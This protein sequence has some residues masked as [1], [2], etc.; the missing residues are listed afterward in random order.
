MFFSFLLILITFSGFGQTT[1]KT[2]L[3]II[4]G[5]KV[6]YSSNGLQTRKPGEPLVVFE[7]GAMSYKENLIRFLITFLKMLPGLLMTGLA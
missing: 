3:V 2:E 6:A 5:K 1:H 7:S 4:N